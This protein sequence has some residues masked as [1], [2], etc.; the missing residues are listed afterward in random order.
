MT[1]ERKEKNIMLFQKPEQNWDK[2]H[3]W[4]QK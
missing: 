1:Q 2:N 3:H 4:S